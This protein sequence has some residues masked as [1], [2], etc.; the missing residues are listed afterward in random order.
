VNHAGIVPLSKDQAA[1]AVA[2]L[3]PGF[4][5]IRPLADCAMHDTIDLFGFAEPAARW[6][7]RKLRLASRSTVVLV[8]DDPGNAEGRGGPAAW[9][10][11]GAIGRWCHAAII[12]AAGGQPAH[13]LEAVRGAM[14]FG[15]LALIETTS[16]HAEAWA[17]CIGCPTTLVILPTDGQHPIDKRVL[18]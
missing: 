14:L 3:P 11:A 2:A 5:F 13:Y 8:G 15:R 1:Q 17:Q 12:H 18:H 7:G 16:R 6:P 10:C 4:G 9:G